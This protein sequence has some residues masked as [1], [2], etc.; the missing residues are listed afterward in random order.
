MQRNFEKNV[1]YVRSKSMVFN[2]NKYDR[3]SSP[4]IEEPK[5]KHGR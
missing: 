3:S 2:Y 1:D 5:I 4:E